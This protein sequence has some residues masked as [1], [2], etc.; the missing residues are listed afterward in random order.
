MVAK[1]SGDTICDNGIYDC[2]IRLKGYPYLHQHQ[3]VTFTARACD[4]MERKLTVLALDC[5]PQHVTGMISFLNRYPPYSGFPLVLSRYDQLLLGYIRSKD[6]RAML[7]SLA[8]DCELV[9]EQYAHLSVEGPQEDEAREQQCD[10]RSTSWLRNMEDCVEEKKPH[11]AAFTTT[12]CDKKV[13]LSE[14]VDE[15]VM[16][17][18]P[19]TPLGQV[20]NI[21]R[22]LGLRLCVLTRH[23]RLEG[24]LTKKQFLTHMDLAHPIDVP[25]VSAQQNWSARRPRE[26]GEDGICLVDMGRP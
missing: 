17:L 26:D 8:G 1:W 20:Y 12:T 25:E 3:Q 19:E 14:L 11:G 4:I 23:G 5:Y 9:F 22:Q 16:Q 18:V 21:F 2:Y 10:N 24:L 13:D 15:H 6:L 7:G